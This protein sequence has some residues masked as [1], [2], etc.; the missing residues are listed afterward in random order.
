MKNLLL[1]AALIGGFALSVQAH[2]AESDADIMMQGKAII[3]DPQVIDLAKTIQEQSRTQ[4]GELIESGDM[5]WAD[6]L[7]KEEEALHRSSVQQQDNI[8]QQEIGDAKPAPHP[9]GTEDRT[10]IFVSWSL[11]DQEIESLLEQY[12]GLP[13]V[14]LVF[15]GIPDGMKM[16]DAL[17]KMQR[18]AYKKKSSVTVLL[19]PTAFQRHG[20]DV[21]PAVVRETG[22]NELIAKVTG[23]S[24]VEYINKALSDGKKGDLGTQGPTS[25]I[26]EQDLIELM[27]ERVAKLDFE[28][29]KKKA[30]N[31]FWK[32]QTFTNLPPASENKVRKVSAEVII[33]SDIVG[34]NG[35]VI[36]AAGSVINPLDAM[37]FT[38]RLVVINP[39]SEFEVGL[40]REQIDAHAKNQRVTL[41]VTGISPDK[42]WDQFKD[43]ENKL[44]APVYLLQPDLQARF[45]IER[46]PSVV[47]ADSESF[48]V[49]EFAPA[50]EVLP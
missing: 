29:M 31:N 21:V 50:S 23:L 15:R 41:I 46:T 2:A 6:E 1:A 26:K 16:A 18:L 13:A 14:G 42:G 10:L 44:D 47:T 49:E 45:N 34:A 19:D 3:A 27:K 35:E 17:A 20:I 4:A 32:K 12:D 7:V 24:S 39:E 33:P 8:G 48:L 5:A 37:P 43:L 38:Q 25:P 30:I 28:A 40:A 22:T 9:M 36:A 11:G